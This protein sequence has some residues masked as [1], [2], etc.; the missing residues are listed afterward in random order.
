MDNDFSNSQFFK[1][2]L[3]WRIPEVSEYLI[4]ITC[5]GNIC[6]DQAMWLTETIFLV[7]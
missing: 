2:S 7:G 6:A 4:L 5:S 1:H 3:D